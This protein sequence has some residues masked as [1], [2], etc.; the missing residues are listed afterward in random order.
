MLGVA[1]RSRSRADAAQLGSMGGPQVVQQPKSTVGPGQA[2][3]SCKTGS[4]QNGIRE[5]FRGTQV[6]SGTQ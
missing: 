6:E 4:T 1:G 2:N 3:S 5:V